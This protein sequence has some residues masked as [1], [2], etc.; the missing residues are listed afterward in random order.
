MWQAPSQGTA[1]S[2]SIGGGRSRLSGEWMRTRYWPCASLR[3][4]AFFMTRKYFPVPVLR[5]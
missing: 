3:R 1:V 4:G 5:W 2:T